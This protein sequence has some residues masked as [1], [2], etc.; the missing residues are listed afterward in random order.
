M[1]VMMHPMSAT[2]SLRKGDRSVLDKQIPK[3][4][5]RRVFRL[6]RPLSTRADRLPDHDRPRCADRRRHPGAGRARVVNQIVGHGSGARRRAASRS[7][8][9]GPGRRRRRALVRPA[10]VL[11]ADRRGTDLRH[12]H[13]GLRP[14]PAH[15][16]R[17]LHPHADGRPGQPP[18][19]RRPGRP[20]G[21]HLDAVGSGVE[22][23]QPRAHGGGDVLA[24]VADHRAVVDPAAD[25]RHP[26]PTHRHPAAGDHPRVLQ[27]ERVDELDDDRALQRRRCSAGQ[28]VRPSRRRGRLVP[29]PGRPRPR[30]RSHVGDVRAGVLR[31]PHPRRRPGPGARVRTGRLLRDQG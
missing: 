17:L 2:R 23:D 28:T 7:T 31:R 6:R 18:Q 19:Q 16:A 13:G 26:G 22:R 10:V 11:R 25:L 1:Y 27:P 24:V 14:R 21:V 15:A 5:W 3:G 30:H 9:A 12:A 29:R 20:A 4:T 8:I